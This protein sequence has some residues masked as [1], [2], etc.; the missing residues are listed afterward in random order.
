MK[1]VLA[2]ILAL[3]MLF[4]LCACGGGGDESKQPQQSVSDG[5]NAAEQDA[6]VI[7]GTANDLVY[8][9]GYWPEEYL[10]DTIVVA[11]S[12]DGGGFAPVGNSS[13]GSVDLCIYEKLMVIDSQGDTHLQLLKSIEQVDELTYECEIWDCIYDTAGNHITAEDVKWSIQ[14]FV[15]N[16]QKGG[17]NCL[18]LLEGDI[19]DINVTGEYTFIWNCSR[20]FGPGELGKNLSNP[21]IISQT[22]YEA[23]GED[24]YLTD[25][26]GTGPYMLESYTVG[27]KA[28]LV[29]NP[30]YWMK[31]IT[32]EEWLAENFYACNCQNVRCIEYDIIQDA[33]TR[34][35]ALEMGDVCAIDTANTADI[36]AYIS[37]PD[38]GISPVRKRVGA[39]LA[40]YFNCSE[41]SPCSDINLRMAICYA[42]DSAAIAAGISYPAYPVYGLQPNMFDAPE[43][44]TTGEGRDYYNYDLEKAKELLAAAGYNGEPLTVMYVDQPAV[45]D[46][47]IMMQS[48]LREAGINIDLLPLEA[49]TLDTYRSNY[50]KW[51]II[52]DIMGGGNYLA[53]TLKKF[54]SGDYTDSNDNIV[55]A[56]RDDKL[57][58]LF[59]A[60][61]DEGTAET[62]EAFDQYFTYEM[63]YGLAIARYYEQTA[64]LG[65]VNAVIN[66]S[67]MML[68]GAFTYND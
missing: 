13:W 61:R 8:L 18:N 16:G 49:G 11:T 55:L 50:G 57:D 31:N 1:K 58:E 22:G 17:V 52:S 14:L 10:R 29:A 38:Y 64:C 51:D 42:V 41:D 21:T 56:I 48:K 30:D 5:A 27:S 20:A 65:S 35:M 45:T 9:D 62:I 63:C 26:I 37:D 68:P 46:T 34:A 3:S 23:S 60:V 53:N 59:L 7:T 25:P 28:V 6:A 39:P 32:D 15:D 12:R 44:W 24:M 19:A 43:S 54:W 47:V 40:F 66:G 67:N 33:A 36:D 4:T 2:L